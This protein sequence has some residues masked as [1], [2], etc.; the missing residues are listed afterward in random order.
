[1]RKVLAATAIATAT[2][3]LLSCSAPTP[4]RSSDAADSLA[5]EP[6]A[7]VLR[8]PLLRPAGYAALPPS[9]SSNDQSANAAEAAQLGWHASPRWAAIKGTDALVD[10]GADCND[11]Q[12]KFKA[13]KAKAKKVGVENLSEDD[14][15]GLSPAQLREL[16]GY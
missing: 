11:P 9:S 4:S 8:T 10:C 2:T 15:E 5:Y 14:V 1:V 12:A 3:G 6:P 7:P 16:R 13:A